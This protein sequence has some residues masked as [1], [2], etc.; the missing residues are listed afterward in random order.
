MSWIGGRLPYFGRQHPSHSAGFYSSP[1]AFVLFAEGKVANRFVHWVRISCLPLHCCIRHL[2]LNLQQNRLSQA[3]LVQFSY[4]QDHVEVRTILAGIKTIMAFSFGRLRPFLLF[5]VLLVTAVLSFQYYTNSPSYLASVQKNEAQKRMEK[6]RL[7]SIALDERLANPKTIQEFRGLIKNRYF[8]SDWEAF[9]QPASAPTVW[10]ESESSRL[11]AM[12]SSH[13]YDLILLPIQEDRGLFDLSARMLSANYLAKY[14]ERSTG[15]K[16]LPPEITLR[17]LGARS[18][19]F[20]DIDV[21]RLATKFNAQVLHQYVSAFSFSGDYT[22]RKKSISLAAFVTNAKGSIV[23]QARFDLGPMEL[24][25][26]Q[27]DSAPADPNTYLEKRIYTSTATIVTSLFEVKETNE[28]KKLVDNPVELILPEKVSDV[29]ANSTSPIEQAARLQLLA[30]FTP[31]ILDYERNRLFE[32]SILAMSD[33]DHRSK[34]Y[35]TLYARALYHLN[36]RPLAVEYLSDR[37]SAEEMALKEVLDGNYYASKVYLEKIASPLLHTLAL[38]EI[39]NL[40]IDY[41]KNSEEIVLHP[42][43]GSE[44]HNLL[45]YVANDHDMWL[46]PSNARFFSSIFGLFPSFDQ[47]IA[48]QLEGKSISGEAKLSVDMDNLLHDEISELIYKTRM[49]CCSE[50]RENVSR[51]DILQLYK[52]LAL[53]NELRK[54]EK[55]V[56]VQAAYTS[57]SKYASKRELRLG[58]HVVFTSLYAEALLSVAESKS[59]SSRDRLFDKSVD[60]IFPLIHQNKHADRGRSDI[61]QA[62]NMMAS[63]GQSKKARAGGEKYRSINEIARTQGTLYRDDFPSD[64]GEY[65]TK[66][67]DV[68]WLYDN[69]DLKCVTK[70]LKKKNGSSIVESIISHRF[71]GHPE[72][73][74]LLAKLLVKRGDKDQAVK[75]L[76]TEISRNSPDWAPYNMLGSMLIQDSDYQG[77]FDAY[78]KYPAF[79]S[80][81]GQDRV[82][83]SNRAEDAGSRLYWLGQYEK[84]K[85]LY[86]I[87]ASLNT[88]AGS[89]LAASQRI[90]LMEKDLAIAMSYAYQRGSRYN[91][92]YGYRDYLAML[93]LLGDHSSVEKGFK[94]LYKR[95]RSPQMWTAMFIGQRIRGL[96]NEDIG[97]WISALVGEKESPNMLKIAQ[98]YKLLT[99][100]TDREVD[101]NSI[102]TIPYEGTYVYVGDP[103]QRYYRLANF[104]KRFDFI[105][106]NHAFNGIDTSYVEFVDA[107]KLLKSGNLEQAFTKFMAFDEKYNSTYP[108]STKSFALPYIMM[109]VS[110][111]KDHEKLKDVLSF[112]EKERA[113]RQGSIEFDAALAQAVIYTHLDNSENALSA[114]KLAFNNRPHTGWR[115][116][117]SWYQLIEVTEWIHQKTGNDIFRQQ[118]LDWVKRYQIIQ[119]QFSWAYAFEAKY[120]T[121]RGERI[122][123][124]GYAFFLDRHSAWLSD[125][126][127]EILEEGVNWWEKNNPFVLKV[128]AHTDNSKLAL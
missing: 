97:L 10:E 2:W 50:S 109:S 108:R 99:A 126:P 24:R 124:A 114:L 37:S 20:R 51:V 92:Q 7:N 66:R 95:Y 102:I 34:H 25:K 104:F 83:I 113:S 26:R 101:S 128:E 5:A 82:A 8:P 17:L 29:G 96:S 88:G 112:F 58:G 127:T 72:R 76:K 27:F 9:D 22:K 19:R 67:C 53:A 44:W 36:R 90:A 42:D 3:T 48:D 65:T 12:V 60:L 52:N 78:T 32:R 103:N 86:R 119:P 49:T 63:I 55:M 30:L 31:K 64:L 118:A 106:N 4:T 54:L 45:K 59:G 79:Q 93:G 105:Q 43:I 38:I 115:P 33:L 94:A 87:S 11:S 21:E 68:T 110:R 120:S 71:D 91:N 121:N 74:I 111:T 61:Q 77:A 35:N 107:Y 69:S 98:R 122:E 75:L 125:V 41:K 73:S 1:I 70:L 6:A 47:H 40:R 23:R 80:F 28:H 18:W 117:Y 84:A 13:S 14:I 39:S 62:Y 85:A 46:A 123:A 81:D 56:R 100:L 116:L 16:V 57:A 89:Q 15:L